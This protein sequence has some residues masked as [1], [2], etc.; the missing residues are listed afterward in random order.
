MNKV[1]DEVD[2]LGLNMFQAR[3]DST[4]AFT[5]LVLKEALPGLGKLLQGS[6]AKPLSTLTPLT[7]HGGGS[8]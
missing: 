8:E 5:K 3:I 2:S 7:R 4:M 6:P 1:P